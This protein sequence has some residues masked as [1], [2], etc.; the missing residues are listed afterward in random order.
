MDFQGKLCARDKVFKLGII[1]GAWIAVHVGA[2]VS[3]WIVEAGITIEARLL[4]TYLVPGETPQTIKIIVIIII[5]LIILIIIIIIIIIIL[6]I[7]IN[8]TCIVLF[9]K[10]SIALKI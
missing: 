8:L 5:I 2:S 9:L 3:L 10:N 7:I 4:E 1:P 6:I